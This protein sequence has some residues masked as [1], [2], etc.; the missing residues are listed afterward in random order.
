M[1]RHVNE[2]FDF[3]SFI[4]DM[5]VPN[6]GTANIQISSFFLFPCPAF[7][8]DTNWRSERGQKIERTIECGGADGVA[9]SKTRKDEK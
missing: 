5:R 8:R 1:W 4:M 7:K 3:L 6:L 2:L 9:F